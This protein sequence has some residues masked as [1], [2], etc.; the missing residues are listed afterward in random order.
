M[1]WYRKRF[2]DPQL[3]TCLAK[4]YKDYQYSVLTKH[5]LCPYALRTLIQIISLLSFQTT[6]SGNSGISQ[7]RYHF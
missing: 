6:F 1:S 4:R 2:A 3:R 7:F 5:I